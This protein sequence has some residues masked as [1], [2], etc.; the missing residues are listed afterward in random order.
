MGIEHKF[1][2]QSPNKK[3]NTKWWRII[4]EIHRANRIVSPFSKKS[5][6]ANQPYVRS[7]LHEGTISK[8]L[9]DVKRPVG[10]SKEL[11]ERNGVRGTCESYTRFP[12]RIQSAR[13]RRAYARKHLSL[14]VRSERLRRRDSFRKITWILNKISNKFETISL[15]WILHLI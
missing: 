7:I 12:A 14:R 1:H 15:V 2:L 4:I 8:G 10:R 11:S 13:S 9:E 3:G 5:S 6:T